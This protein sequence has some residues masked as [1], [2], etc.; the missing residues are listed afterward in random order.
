MENG[1]LIKPGTIGSS[2]LEIE[3]IASAARLLR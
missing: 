2:K 3:N 1:A